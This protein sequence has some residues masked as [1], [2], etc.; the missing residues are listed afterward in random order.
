MDLAEA[1]RFLNQRAVVTRESGLF[2]AAPYIDA[3]EQT[4]IGVPERARFVDAMWTILCNGNEAEQEIAATFLSKCKMPE[5][6]LRAAVCR[7]INTG[8]DFHSALAAVIDRKLPTDAFEQ[9]YFVYSSDPARHARF[10][11]MI[12]SVRR[13]SWASILK[14]VRESSDPDALAYAVTAA[15]T[16][17]RDAE[18]SPLL[19]TKPEEI[20]REAANRFGLREPLP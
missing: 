8:L 18:L 12:L 14:I 13:D 16:E 19:K 2:P 5:D 9:L 7:Y 10:A 17:G 4:P 11:A 6:M 1:W 3:Y 20:L 15:W